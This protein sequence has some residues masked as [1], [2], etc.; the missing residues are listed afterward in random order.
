VTVYVL[1]GRRIWQLSSEVHTQRGPGASV[2]ARKLQYGKNASLYLIAFLIT[3][4][5]S[6]ANRLYA[7]YNPF[8]PSFVLSVMMSICS[9]ARGFTN[10]AVYFYLT[11]FSQMKAASNSANQMESSQMSS[12]RSMSVA[13][14]SKSAR[15][16][17]RV[18]AQK[19]AFDDL[20]DLDDDD[21]IVHG[22]SSS[23][24]NAYSTNPIGTVDIHA[25][26][27]TRP[28]N[29]AK[30]SSGSDATASDPAAHGTSGG[31]GNRSS[32]GSVSSYNMRAQMPS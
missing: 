1:V 3:W 5:P 12:S 8:H 24:S 9:P 4:T 22:K 26:S 6:S 15:E 2:H 13:S 31:T 32:M 7:F 30:S 14:E 27:I 17:R 16:S 18:V 19:D 11:F 25:S 29:V 23:A 21:D 10:F 28:P 20:S